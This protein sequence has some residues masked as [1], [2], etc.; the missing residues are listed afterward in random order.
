M[1]SVPIEVFAGFDGKIH[2]VGADR[3]E[4]WTYIYTADPTVLTAGAAIADLSGDGVPEI[5]F[6]TYSTQADRSALIVL[7]AAG[8]ERARVALPGRGAMAV[9]TVADVDRDGTLEV[10]VSL[11]DGDASGGSV[12][13]FSVPGSSPNCLPWPTGRANPLRTGYVRAK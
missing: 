3:R 1:P 6:A 13:V 9:P 11:K 7:D 5:L 12:L 4:R 10:L 8:A 2:L